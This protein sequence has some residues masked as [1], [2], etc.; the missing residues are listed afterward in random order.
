MRLGKGKKLGSDER[1]NSNN[2]KSGNEFG[3]M[4]E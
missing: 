1:I 3:D 4:I 2:F